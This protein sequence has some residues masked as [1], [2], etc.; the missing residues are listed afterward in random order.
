MTTTT[1][2]DA[3]LDGLDRF[4][5]IPDWLAA[6][7]RPGRL[8]SSLR[9][10]VPEL[11]SRSLEL[12]DCRADRLRAKDDQWLVRCRVWVAPA[13]AAAHEQPTEVVLAGRLL[14]PGRLAPQD[15]T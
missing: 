13:G 2:R 11:S 4:A 8:E 9:S 10:H 3:V 5:G 12:V 15:G 1:A 6:P 7:M 14:P